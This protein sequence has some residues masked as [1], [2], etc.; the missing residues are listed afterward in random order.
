MLKNSGSHQKINDTYSKRTPRINTI[1]YLLVVMLLL[2]FSINIDKSGPKPTF[3][4]KSLHP[5]LAL[6]TI[7]PVSLTYGSYYGASINNSFNDIKLDDHGNIY[8]FGTTISQGF[9]AVLAKFD[10]N[11]NLIWEQILGG[12]DEENRHP[13]NNFDY[14]KITIDQLGNCYVTGITSSDDFPLVNAF[15]NSRAGGTDAFIAKFDPDGQLVFSSYLGGSQN[16]NELGSG[17]VAVDQTGNIFVTGTTKSNSFFDQ[18]NSFQSTLS[19]TA[20]ADI[21][22]VKISAD[23][24]TVT[25]TYWGDENL[26]IASSIELTSDNNIW[27]GGYSENSSLILPGQNP[28][29]FDARDGILLGFNHGLSNIIG[30]TFYGGIFDDEINDLTIDESDNIFI[31]GNTF[32]TSDFPSLNAFQTNYQG[33]QMAFMAKFT[34]SAN[35]LISTFIGGTQ[36]ET[37]NGIAVNSLGEIF[38]TGSTS[39]PD[40][41]FH[42]T[43]QETYNNWNCNHD[44]YVFKFNADGTRDWSSAYGGWRADDPKALTVNSSGQVILVGKTASTDLPTTTNA[45]QQT[46]AFAG[47]NAFLSIFEITCPSVP[48]II[49]ST[50]NAIYHDQFWCSSPS[51]P[52]RPHFLADSCALLLIAPPGYS[53]YEWTRNGSGHGN[54]QVIAARNPNS[55]ANDRYHLKLNDGHDCESESIS[56]PI[57][58]GWVRP[59]CGF[60]SSFNEDELPHKANI[61]EGTTNEFYCIGDNISFPLSADG[62]CGSSWQWQRNFENIPNETSEHFIVTEP[63]CYRIGITNEFTGCTVYSSSKQFILLDSIRLNSREDSRNCLAENLVDGCTDVE[64]QVRM[65]TCIGCYTAPSG[66]TYEFYLD[67]VLFRSSTSSRL[68]TSTPGDYSVRVMKNGCE[69]RSNITTVQIRPT[70]RPTW[71]LPNSN[72]VCMANKDSLNFTISHP[73]ANDSA[74]IRFDFPYPMLD[75]I[76]YDSTITAKNLESGCMDV[77]LTRRD[78]CQSIS[79]RIELHDN[80][81]NLKIELR[82]TSCIPARLDIDDIGSCEM[83]SI[84]WYKGDTLVYD[85]NYLARYTAD[86]PGNY[87]AKIKNA[88]GEFFSDTI[89][90]RGNLPIADISPSG[91]VCLPANI[92]LDFQNPDSSIIIH[93]YRDS[94]PSGC[95]QSVNNLIPNEHGNTLV[96]GLP[97]YYFAILEDTITG[98]KSPCTDK[99][100][101]QRSVAGAGILP[102]NNIYFCGGI[103]AGIQTFTV[104]PASS[105]FVYQWYQNNSPIPGA[106]NPTYTTDQEGVYRVHLENACDNAFTPTVSVFNIANPVVTIANPDTIFLCGPDTI[107]LLAQSDQP[108]LFQWFKD[109]IEIPDAIDSIL[110]TTTP[111]SYEVLGINNNSQCEDYSREIKILNSVIIDANITMNPSCNNTCSGS[112]TANVSGGIPFSGNTYNY[113]WSNGDNTRTIS[114][115]CVGTYRLTITDKVGCNTFLS[116]NLTS[117]FTLGATVDS[118]TCYGENSGAIRTNIQGGL[119]PFS[120]IWNTGATTASVVDLSPGNYQVTVSDGGNCSS[121]AAYE[122]L[123]PPPLSISL[124]AIDLTCQGSNNGNIQITT[125][126]GKLPHSLSW[127]SPVYPDSNNLIPGWYQVTLTDAKNC[128]L[129]DSI[130]VLEPQLLEV[131]LQIDNALDCPGS[132]DGIISSNVT[133]GTTPYSFT[134]STGSSSST[135]NNISS[136]TFSITVTDQQNCQAFSSIILP[137][138]QNFSINIDETQHIDCHGSASG[139]IKTALIGGTSPVQ[140]Y[141]N[142][143]P[144]NNSTIENL[145]AGDYQIYAI[146][147]NACRTALVTVTLTEPLPIYTTLSIDSVSCFG[148]ATGR[149]LFSTSG[150]TGNYSYLWD[151][152]LTINSIDTLRSGNYSITITDSLACE[153][154]LTFSIHEPLPITTLFSIKNTDCFQSQTGNINSISSSGGNP[155]YRYYLQGENLPIDHQRLDSLVAGEYQL[156]TLDSKDCEMKQDFEI[157]E[158]ELL[159]ANMLIQD[160]IKCF[161]GSNGQLSIV[162]SGGT[163]PYSFEWSNGSNGPEI[164]ELPSGIYSL[165]LTDQ[166]GCTA[167]S[168]VEL[169]DGPFLEIAISNQKNLSCEGANDGSATIEALGGTPP[170]RFYINQDSS[171]TGSFE[172]LPAGNYSFYIK[173]KNECISEISRIEITAPAL[174]TATVNT[175]PVLCPDGISGMAEIL[176]QGGTAPYTYLWNNG[177][178]NKEV[179]TLRAGNYDVTITDSQDCQTTISFTIHQPG[180]IRHDFDIRHA[181]CYGATNGNLLILET[182]GGTANYQYYFEDSLLLSGDLFIDSLAAGTYTL[183]TIDQQGCTQVTDILIQEPAALNVDMGPDQVI[184]LGESTILPIEFTGGFDTLRYQISPSNYLSCPTANYYDCPAPTI[185]QPLEDTNYKIFFS[186]GNGCTTTDSVNIFVEPADH[187]IYMANAFNPFSLSGNE[188]LFVQATPVVATIKNFTVYNRWGATVFS[189]TNFPPNDKAYGWNGNFN[190][191]IVG[192]G[193]FIYQ[194][195]F[196]TIDGKE[197]QQMGDVTVLW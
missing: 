159:L 82:G 55:S 182:T 110:Q 132:T 170:F 156:I 28:T 103:G 134:W 61:L 123:P 62:F 169:T 66:L 147:A 86:E 158:P 111:G 35:L 67:G 151:N 57:K 47:V 80:L 33:G 130:E 192:T 190:G 150:G 176:P 93:W 65:N 13:D 136:D 112:L 185:Q 102:N 85:R 60:G 2:F 189:A 89:L 30:G 76:G 10:Q 69:I 45:F 4:Y 142:N 179:N 140:L 167:T 115:L 87:Y 124:N 122:L 84:F 78:G 120:Y 49:H 127:D 72:A 155:S 36:N 16:E 174:L 7:G 196:E 68:T 22:V 46:A 141:L 180:P 50:E 88:C 135:L 92:N 58:P 98:C 1:N 113:Q 32:S 27:V 146:D 25:G 137:A 14:G 79:E 143:N 187:F 9:D 116:A 171:T 96:A 104:A 23:Y 164:E 59:M 178:T 118:V 43:V 81:L 75:V 41:P 108:I 40:F 34:N 29:A 191:E 144:I 52:A 129:V 12:S 11:G 70:E 188:I 183:K 109:G 105:S 193:V 97:G 42:R 44:G 74:V 77:D 184:N 51:N 181:S 163:A 117:G 73:A 133:G 139:S 125:S 154:I 94:A 153:E 152:G 3:L 101:V 145:S 165:T 99:V 138:V 114:D 177:L 64:L 5:S 197:L 26:D 195:L 175:S 128:N 53:S 37:G 148:S 100:E 107:S 18:S 106:T 168:S 90:I 91:P 126:G 31:V 172:N 48:I 63:G 131:S 166:Q 186:D 161:G 21:F 6:N 54:G 8:A 56:H 119:A 71:V 149:A 173:D 19:G 160:S 17:A 162:S 15:Q 83:D 38:V 121:V 95:S 157:T 20:E 194:V 24:S 39:S